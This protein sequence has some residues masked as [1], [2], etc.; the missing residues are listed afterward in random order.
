MDLSRPC[1]AVVATCVSSGAEAKQVYFSSLRILLSTGR[2]SL[3]AQVASPSLL[4]PRQWYASQG[5][6]VQIGIGGVA[7]F[8]GITLLI[9]VVRTVS[10]LTHT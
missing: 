8:A 6:Q 9:A 2:M 7:A 1:L 5:R 10:S 3:Q 4:Q